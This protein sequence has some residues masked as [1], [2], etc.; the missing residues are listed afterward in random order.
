MVSLLYVFVR[1][2]PFAWK[3]TVPLA[4]TQ[5]RHGRMHAPALLLLFLHLW[6]SLANAVWLQLTA[7]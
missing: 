5:N 4:E 7:W 6:L 3:T 1:V 2:D